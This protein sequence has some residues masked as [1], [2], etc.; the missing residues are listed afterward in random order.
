MSESTAGDKRRFTDDRGE[1]NGHDERQP[2]QKKTKLEE[3]KQELKIPALTVTRPTGPAAPRFVC[4]MVSD[5]GKKRYQEDKT[6]IVQDLNQVV[7][8]ALT[9]AKFSLFAGLSY[10]V[11]LPFLLSFVYI[12]ICIYIYILVLLCGLK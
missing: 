12:Y 8:P 4:Y 1:G 5:Q 9:R 11:S 7:T 6:T 3:N 2:L 10:S